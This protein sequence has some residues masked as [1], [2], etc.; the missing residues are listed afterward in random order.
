[1]TFQSLVQIPRVRGRAEKQNRVK[2]Q[3]FDNPQGLSG[4]NFDIYFFNYCVVG[5]LTDDKA[6]NTAKN[7]TQFQW[8]SD[9]NW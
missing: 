8:N 6:V 1:M 2:P 3:R 5:V 9:C 4:R 7:L